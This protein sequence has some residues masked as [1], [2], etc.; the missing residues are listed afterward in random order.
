MQYRRRQKSEK[1]NSETSFRPQEHN[2]TK[3]NNWF[4]RKEIVRKFLCSYYVIDIELSES[5]LKDRIATF[6]PQPSFTK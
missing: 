3:E 4:Y 5:L 1:Q 6:E 2:V